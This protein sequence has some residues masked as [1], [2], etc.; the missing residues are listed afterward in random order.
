MKGEYDTPF[1]EARFPSVSFLKESRR[2]GS[3]NLNSKKVKRH[4]P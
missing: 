4:R 2:S 3:N 1:V